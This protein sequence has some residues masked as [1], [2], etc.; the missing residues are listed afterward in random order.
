MQLNMEY[1]D[2]RIANVDTGAWYVDLP[3]LNMA[4]TK[5]HRLHHVD[6]SI[7]G[8]DYT[9]PSSILG[10]LLRG[11]DAAMGGSRIFAGGNERGAVRL[12]S[13]SKYGIDPGKGTVG[14]AVEIMSEATKPF[15]VYVTWFVEYLPK[16]TPGYREARL[17]W[18]DVTNCAKDSDF[19]PSRGVYRRQSQE[20]KMQHDGEF[21]F[22][23]G[24]THDGGVLVE[25]YVN[26]KLSCTSKQIYANRRGGFTEPNDDKSILNHLIMPAGSHI[27]DVAVC[28]DWGSVKKGDA[29][30]VKAY[31]DEG[32]HMQ[33]MNGK[34][35]LEVQMG[36]MWTY[37]GLKN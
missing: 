18:V 6:I 33:M 14:G 15:T 31:Y 4:N 9:C 17:V 24:H 16:S 26:G 12:N 32:Q 36:L 27:S 5:L 30:S 25:L 1:P 13:K 29:L 8:V 20:F 10:T 28:K 35:E 7:T 22:A 23:N 2:G 3:S 34:G 37:V 21:L 19:V 11:G